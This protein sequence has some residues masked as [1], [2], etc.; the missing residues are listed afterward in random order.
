MFQILKFSAEVG[1]FQFVAKA[2]E[3]TAKVRKM[4]KDS[5]CFLVLNLD[6]NQP[7]IWGRGML[8]KWLALFPLKQVLEVDIFV[9]PEPAPERQPVTKPHGTR[10][11]PFVRK[12]EK[13]HPM[14]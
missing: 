5:N 11:E 14:W 12:G 6:T 1:A 7:L 4:V 2:R 13:K 10:F 9:V 3:L 8:A